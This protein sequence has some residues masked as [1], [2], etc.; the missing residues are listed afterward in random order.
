M[1]IAL[2]GG[3]ALVRAA[4]AEAI[5]R[6][7]RKGIEAARLGERL[8]G[9][10]PPETWRRA[11]E[12]LEADGLAVEWNRRWLALRWTDWRVGV[13]QL[14]DGGDALIRSGERGEVGWFVGRRGL[15]TARDGDTVL[16][17]PVRGRRAG[18]GSDLPPATVVKV[19]RRGITRVVGTLELSETRRWLIPF[20]PKTSL[21]L[22]VEGGDDL[23]EDQYVVAEVVGDGRP[24]GGPLRGRVGEVLGAA[25][26]PGVDVL[27]VLR[28]LDI[29]DR[30]PERVLAE[31]EGFP[32]DPGPE[33]WRG[34]E[35][36][37]QRVAVTI[38][39]ET[40]R[41]FDDAISVERRPGGGFRLGVHIADVSH[42][43]G[44][45]S[46]L[47]LEAYRRGTS[48]Y[49]PD[50]AVPMLPE[51]LSNGLCS[52]RPEVPRLTLSAFLDIDP[53]GRVTSRRFAETVIESHRRLTYTEVRRLLEEPAPGDAGEYGAV[54]PLLASARELMEVLHRTRVERGS[55]DFDLPQGD[56]ILDTDGVTV[57][58][59][60]GERNVAHRII[61][62][63][64]IAA[65][66]AVALELDGREADALYRV[67]E[68]PDP[69]DLEELKEILRS[70]GIALKGDLT[71]LHPSAL[72][73][74]LARVEGRPE[75]PFVSTLVLRAMRRAAYEPLCRGHYALAARHYTH[76]TSPIRRYP[77]LLVH[78][79][80]KAEVL[81]R[82]PGAAERA[83][84]GERLGA[85]AE[86]TSSTERRA[87]RAERLILQWKLVRLLADRVG[88]EFT[89]RITG[90][91]PFG[92]FV[93][94]V[95]F[96]VDGLV[97]IRSLA[98][99]F[100]VFDQEKHR[101]SGREHGHVFRL[102]DEVRVV[103]TG[104]DARRRGLDLAIA[105]MPEPPPRRE[106]R[107]RPGRPPRRGR[108]DRPGPPRGSGA[109]P[110]RKGRSERRRRR[111]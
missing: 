95:D 91:Q 106:R 56:V 87:E 52:L 25:D 15:K 58:V 35:D 83:R 1:S 85:I 53:G 102:A 20:D 75:E 71:D 26:S 103:L 98:D 99:D 46:T 7:G 24:R 100:Y 57:G 74:V 54:L 6:S 96:Y 48:V 50:R 33:D 22:E 31:A 92:L 107:E 13:A 27:V 28:H 81:G 86:Q 19:L 41:D 76:F 84:L 16:I 79:Q 10:F 101:L 104:V 9:R 63:C 111:R 5:E 105:G 39:G 45:G 49:F 110:S 94:L 62:E 47:D 4:V 64:M 43:V 93:Q 23:L 51:A 90:V 60:P 72:Q 78:R 30:F 29:P 61:E 44:E 88:E 59:K 38:D 3:E 18:R 55:I 2:P 14:L 77:D 21:D 80:L 70:L 69:T 11:L 67:H 12:E 65:N 108:G 34:R 68:A 97:P 36:L 8:D 82:D 73:K 32:A 66:E 40:A 42:Y 37:R 109:G 17:K 89:G